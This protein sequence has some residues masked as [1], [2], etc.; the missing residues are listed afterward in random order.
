VGCRYKEG[1]TAYAGIQRSLQQEW[2]FVQRVID[3]IGDEFLLVK[4]ALK[5]EFLPAFFRETTP[6]SIHLWKVT[7]PLPVKVLGLSIPNAKLLSA[8]KIFRRQWIVVH[9]WLTRSWDAGQVG[10]IWITK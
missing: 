10:I 8:T 2:Q 5:E 7:A 4:A 6:I 9:F 1:N 3:R